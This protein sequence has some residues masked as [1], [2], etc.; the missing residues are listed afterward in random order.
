VIV[1]WLL[2]MVAGFVTF[3]IGLFPTVTVPEWMSTTVP[4]AIASVNAYLLN[5][6]VWLPFDHA[7]TALGLVLV[8]LAAAVTIKLIR[9]TASF[10]TG[11]GGSAA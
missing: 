3:I 4:G 1:K 2:D 11:G 6:S 9:V 5:V 8:A 10:F 7:T